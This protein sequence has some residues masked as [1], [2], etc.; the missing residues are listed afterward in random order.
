MNFFEQLERPDLPRI[1]YPFIKR[2]TSLT[3]RLLSAYMKL[4]NKRISPMKPLALVNGMPVYDLTQAPLYSQPGASVLRNGFEYIIL[5]RQAQPITMTLMLNGKCNMACTHCSART[6]M[7]TGGEMLSWEE[8]KTLVDQFVDAGGSSVVISGGEPTLHPHLVDLV[9]Y[10]PKDKAVVSMFSNGTNVV[11]LLPDLKAA[12]LFGTLI[13][14]DSPIPAIHDERRR[15]QG[16]YDAA[17]EALQALLGADMLAGISTYMTRPDLHAGQFEKMIELGTE[18]G[19]LQL[20][21]FDTVP[22]GAML[23]EDGGWVLS[24]EDRD[25]CQKLTMD[26]NA[27]PVG[28]AIMG[29]SWVNSPEGFGCFA[30]FY[31]MYV[32]ASGDVCPCDFTPITFGNVR[33]DSVGKIW[34]RI[35]LSEDWNIQHNECRM[36]DAGFRSNTVDLLPE[37]TPLPVPYDKVLELRRARDESE[38]AAATADADPGP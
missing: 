28:P 21:V 1:E 36:Q 11:E 30:G 24:R 6:Y 26:Q 10:V 35:R 14:L 25:L 15:T 3:D 31:Q 19:A 22:T 16:A 27:N 18:L 12:G 38:L 20:F 9:D 37:G 33:E 4:F 34:E 29:Q 17:V 32:T 23:E 7:R 5:K 8:L 13:S 2:A